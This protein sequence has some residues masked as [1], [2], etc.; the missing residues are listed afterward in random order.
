MIPQKIAT[1]IMSLRNEG[2]R[3]T[4]IAMKS[5]RIAKVIIEGREVLLSNKVSGFGNSVSA[6]MMNNN[7]NIF[8]F[9]CCKEG[10]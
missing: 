3:Y 6:M 7:D 4:K 9:R 8:S 10:M 2:F 1:D 5:P